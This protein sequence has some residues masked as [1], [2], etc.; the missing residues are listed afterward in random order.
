VCTDG[1]TVEEED[2]DEDFRLHSSSSDCLSSQS[3]AGAIEE[4]A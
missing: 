4:L 1:G 3:F 2:D